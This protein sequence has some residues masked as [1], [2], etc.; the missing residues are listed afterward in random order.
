MTFSFSLYIDDLI[1]TDN[2]ENMILA[3]KSDMMRRYEMSDIG[4]LY[5]FLKI[6]IKPRE[7]SIF[8]YQKKYIENILKK[9]KMKNCNIVAT[10]LVV[11]E[12]FMKENKS[13]E[14]NALLYRSIIESL[15]ISQLQDR[16]F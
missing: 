10:S 3:F 14:A 9:F 4:L 16:I 11:N 2:N 1:I 13:G 12:K 15:F 6:E 7:D 8:I 5:Y